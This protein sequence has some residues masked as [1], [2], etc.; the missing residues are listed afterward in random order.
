VQA[1]LFKTVPNSYDTVGGVGEPG[2]AD[3]AA[4]E[5]QSGD[6]GAARDR[7]LARAEPEKASRGGLSR[8]FAH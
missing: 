6:E 1:K 7:G 2:R 3:R 4:G 5:E 8:L